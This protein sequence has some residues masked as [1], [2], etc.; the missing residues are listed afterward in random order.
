[1]AAFFVVG[2]CL[3]FLLLESD[4]YIEVV[5]F[6]AVFTEAM[7]GT[8]QFYRNFQNRST[9]G[10]S[11]KMVGC[12]MMGDTFKT[13]YFILREAPVQFWVCGLMQVSIDLAILFQ[14]WLYKGNVPH[15]QL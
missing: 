4:I 10:M 2:F 12:W 5:G 8:P 7:L 14:V 1:M 15:R 11:V 9:M 6:L 13:G 3:T